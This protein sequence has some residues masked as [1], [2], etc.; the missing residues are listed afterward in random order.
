MIRRLFKLISYFGQFFYY[1]SIKKSDE[2]YNV[3]YRTVEEFGG[4]Y[5]KLIQFFS[6]RTDIF[7]NKYKVMFLCFYDFVTPQALDVIKYL[8]KEL[9][10][11]KFSQ[12]NS[13]CSKLTRYLNK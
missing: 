6:L 5:I 2:F 11:K 7:P 8:Y 9:G 12:M 10:P 3:I 4:I 13:P 1:K